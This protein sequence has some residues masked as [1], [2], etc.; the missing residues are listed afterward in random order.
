MR[1]G[2]VLIYGFEPSTA[3]DSRSGAAILSS[4]RRISAART[5]L[6]IDAGQRFDMFD[7]AQKL[8]HARHFFFVIET[9]HRFGSAALVHFAP[10]RAAIGIFLFQPRLA[11]MMK[12]G[13]RIT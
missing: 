2:A 8:G 5:A 9:F 12:L 4:L 3:D 7:G 6:P 11:P 1:S 10:Q 13:D